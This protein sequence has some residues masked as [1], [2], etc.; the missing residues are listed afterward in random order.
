RRSSSR[1]RR[2]SSR[3]RLVPTTSS[4]AWT[5]CAPVL[6]ILTY[7]GLEADEFLLALGCCADQHQ[8]AFGGFFHTG[9]QVDPVRPHVHVSPR[10][11][12]ALLP[13]VVIRLPFCRQ[14][15]DHRRRQVRCVLAQEGGEFFLEVAGR[16][17][18]QIENR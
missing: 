2:S 5:A 14:P 6:C 18:T 13:G 10:R 12:V 4:S 16:Y 8:H 11:E 7:P 1:T 15:R 3:T 9:L 17:P